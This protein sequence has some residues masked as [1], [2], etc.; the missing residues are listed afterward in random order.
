MSVPQ[1]KSQ[2]MRLVMTLVITCLVSGAVLAAVYGWMNPMIEARKLEQVKSVGLQGIFP[3]VDTFTEVEL[4]KLPAGVE[5]PVYKVFDK[6]GKELGI[7]FTGRSKGYGGD[8]RMAIGVNPDNATLVGVRVLEQNETAGLGSRITEESFLEQLAGKAL[9]DPF[10]IGS[11]LNGITAATISSRAVFDGASEM[12][13]GVLEAM[14]ISIEVA[15]APAAP[16]EEPAAPSAGGD[17]FAEAIRSIV[18]DDA[19]VQSKGLWEIREGDTLVGVGMITAKPGFAG[20]IE[21][22]TVVDPATGAI[23]GV[24]VLHEQETPGLGTEVRKPFFVDQFIG[25]TAEDALTVGDDLD[26]ITMATISS[27][28]VA[29]AVREATETILQLYSGS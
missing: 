25:K 3:D 27:Q 19:A 1:A 21:V 5:A 26:G 2:S 15:A 12:G 29:D 6:S 20:D 23:K 24:R 13:R 7:W 9:S 8:V 18:G 11:D 28:A 14:G 10:K 4:A 22:L 16:A 17:E